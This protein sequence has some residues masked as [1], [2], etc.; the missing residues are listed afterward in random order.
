MLYDCRYGDI[1]KEREKNPLPFCGV[2]FSYRRSGRWWIMTM[3]TEI[4]CNVRFT[5]NPSRHR[6]S[7]YVKYHVPIALLARDP[8]DIAVSYWHYLHFR[9]PFDPIDK[10]SLWAFTKSH[11][12]IQRIIAFLNGWTETNTDFFLIRYEDLKLSFGQTIKGLMNWFGVSMNHE[13]LDSIAKITPQDVGDRS[14]TTIRLISKIRSRPSDKFVA[15]D[16]ARHCRR[17]EVGAWKDY[18]TEDQ[19][20]WINSEMKKLNPVY[21]YA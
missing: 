13:I 21:R 10:M 20:D 1:R 12:G 18:Y 17:S 8:R 2:L 7:H 11:F 3:C 4:G 6:I 19:I 5:H 14:V 16:R 9:F 15:D